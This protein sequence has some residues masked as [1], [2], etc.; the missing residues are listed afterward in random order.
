MRNQFGEGS[1][2]ALHGNTLVVQW[3][4]QAGSFIVALDKRTGEERWRVARDEI[5]G[6]A[7]P[8]VVSF[9]C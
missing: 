9:I 2:P 6:W 1:S 4:H 3:D 5:D 7:T 8:L